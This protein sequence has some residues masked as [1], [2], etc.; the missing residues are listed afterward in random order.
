MELCVLI[1]EE[2]N[3]SIDLSNQA[4]T[5]FVHSKFKIEKDREFYILDGDFR[6]GKVSRMCIDKYINTI[7]IQINKIV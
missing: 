4:T 1:P 7:S 2:L 3:L 5:F 6:L